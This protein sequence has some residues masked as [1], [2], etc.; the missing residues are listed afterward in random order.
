[1][2]GVRP[3]VTVASAHESGD[4]E[5][6]LTKIDYPDRRFTVTHK[7]LPLGTFAVAIDLQ[8]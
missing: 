1:M 8:G 5:K 7:F 3:S 2:G 4:R 6:K